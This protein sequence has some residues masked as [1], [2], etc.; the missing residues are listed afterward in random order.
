MRKGVLIA[1]VGALGAVSFEPAARAA[2]VSIT[3]T[4]NAQ[5]AISESG[6]AS[7]APNSQILQVINEEPEENDVV[8]LEF[9]LASLP[10]NAVVTA[11]S[12]NVTCTGF[13]YP[14][15][16]QIAI[17]A[18][19]GDGT[20]TS[21]D[22]FTAASLAATAVPTSLGSYSTALTPTVLQPIISTHG[23]LAFRLAD[24]VS[25]NLFDFPSILG[26]SSG[27]GAAPSVLL[28]YV[29]PEPAGSALMGIGFL[30]VLGC[31]PRRNRRNSAASAAAPSPASHHSIP[32]PTPAK[33]P[34][35]GRSDR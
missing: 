25:S 18:Y 3:T 19:A 7:V 1:I 4:A 8:V 29:V 15:Y 14:P 35:R 20:I 34:S 23:Y 30:T 11:A 33:S 16:P 9:S 27:D 26:A 5:V 32:P 22:A 24:Q 13:S 6:T 31:N 12:L 21:A 2:S 10:S 28:T 17:G